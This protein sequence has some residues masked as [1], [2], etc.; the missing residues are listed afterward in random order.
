M[1]EFQKFINAILCFIDGY[2][3][4][5]NEESK[6]YLLY[7]IVNITADVLA[8]V[9]GTAKEQVIQF[10]QNSDEHGSNIAKFLIHGVRIER[11]ETNGKC[12]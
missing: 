5:I 3:S 11:V 9:T 8:E 10:M 2:D 1:K 6:I 7:M 4:E 12:N